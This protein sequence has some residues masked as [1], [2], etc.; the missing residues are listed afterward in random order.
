VDL[1]ALA[2]EKVAQTEQMPLWE[3]ADESDRLNWGTFVGR[4]RDSGLLDQSNWIVVTEDMEKRF[5]DD[6]DLVR[7]GHWAVGWVEEMFVRIRDEH[8]RLTPAFEAAAIWKEKLD[9]YPI[10][11][12][13]HFSELEW[14]ATMKNFQE[15]AHQYLKEKPPKDWFGAMIEWFEHNEP[16]AFESVDDQGGYPDD[17]KMMLALYHAGALDEDYVTEL[18]KRKLIP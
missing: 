3:P 10:A 2:K 15:V 18:V 4:H 1:E 11:D 17:D 9:D 5:P 16:N 14:D 7:F 13:M 8:G 12:E 6:V